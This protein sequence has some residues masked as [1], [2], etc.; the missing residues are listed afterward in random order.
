MEAGVRWFVV[1]DVLPR[2]GQAVLRI[3]HQGV[4]PVLGRNGRG[5]EAEGLAIGRGHDDF[6][7]PVAED[8]GGEV[9]AESAAASVECEDAVLRAGFLVPFSD[10]PG[11]E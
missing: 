4:E 1:N 8:V 7:A 9:W 10:G 5:V 2:N 6:F 3:V 11:A